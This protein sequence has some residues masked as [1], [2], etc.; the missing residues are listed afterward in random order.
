MILRRSIGAWSRASRWIVWPSGMP[1]PIAR[2]TLGGIR[3][4]AR[5]DV[6]RSDEATRRNIAMSREWPWRMSP[7]TAGVPAD[8]LV[9]APK[10]ASQRSA[11]ART[12]TGAVPP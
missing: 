9:S 7:I 4:A 3:P 12:L 6:N 10:A 5:R 11:C 2:F 8:Q 1:T